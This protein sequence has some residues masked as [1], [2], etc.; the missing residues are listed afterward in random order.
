M[1]AS[2]SLKGKLLLTVGLLTLLGYVF[3]VLLVSSRY[4]KSLESALEAQGSTLTQSLAVQLADLIL[5]NDVTAIQKLLD[6][7]VE[8]HNLSYVF[9]VRSSRV[10][11]HTFD[12]GGVPQ[13]LLQFNTA[14]EADERAVC[15]TKQFMFAGSSDVIVDVACPIYGGKAGIV[16]LG[17][18]K[19]HI[20]EQLVGLWVQTALA[21]LA[22]LLLTLGGGLPAP[23]QAYPPAGNTGEHY[24]TSG[25]GA[26]GDRAETG[27]QRNTGA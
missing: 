18:S 13:E 5:I 1:R 21:T 6:S 8:Q 23:A 15:N 7:L 9:I 4:S 11:A 3:I 16:H 12:E 17:V 26:T 25:Q 2:Q 20:Q 19:K 22:V 27:V 14:E 10:L 24:K